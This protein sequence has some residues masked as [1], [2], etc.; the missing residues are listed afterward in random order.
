MSNEKE[1]N[2]DQ[3][4]PISRDGSDAESLTNAID[5]LTG[6]RQLVRQ[7]KNRHIAMIRYVEIAYSQASRSLTPS[8]KL[9]YRRSYWNRSADMMQPL[10]FSHF[11]CC[12]SLPGYSRRT[13]Q[14]GTSW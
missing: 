12:R 14:W 6:E 9:Q 13:R 11:P 1:K 7:L 10:H 4:V 3:E 8:L 2:V 5:P